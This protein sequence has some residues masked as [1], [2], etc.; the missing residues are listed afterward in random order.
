MPSPHRLVQ[1]LQLRPNLA[2]VPFAEKLVD[3]GTMENFA[4]YKGG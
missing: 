3:H 2:R 4:A 1:A